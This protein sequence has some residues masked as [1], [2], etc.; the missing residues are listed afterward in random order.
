MTPDDDADR[1]S[2]AERLAA[3]IVAIADD[4]SGDIL[5]TTNAKQETIRTP[6]REAIA[7]AKLRIDTRMWLMARLAPHLYGAGTGKTADAEPMVAFTV[8]THEEAE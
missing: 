8:H 1:L 7:R 2:K 4:I 3:E 6:N 5:T